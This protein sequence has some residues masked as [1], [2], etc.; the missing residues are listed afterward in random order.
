MNTE[1]KT[2]AIGERR[3]RRRASSKWR[4]IRKK[5]LNSL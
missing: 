4:S 2:K 3:R 1:K 5:L